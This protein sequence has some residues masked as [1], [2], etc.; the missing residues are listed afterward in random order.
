MTTDDGYELS[1]VRLLDTLTDGTLVGPDA[2]AGS[3]G[4]VLLQHTVGTDGISWTLGLLETQDP[5]LTL[6]ETLF[7]AG[8]DVWIAN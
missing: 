1:M 6:P 5:P 2:N 3:K 8:Y 4:P 7:D